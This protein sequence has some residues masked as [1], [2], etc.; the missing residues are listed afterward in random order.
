LIDWLIDWLMDWF[1]VRY[2]NHNAGHRYHISPHTTANQ[3]PSNS[4]GPLG[5][6]SDSDN[7]SSKA[8]GL[9]EFRPVTNPL[10]NGC[11]LC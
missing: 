2:A 6:C 7:A 10:C 9:L 11:S 3:T 1:C 5:N 4:G 8:Q